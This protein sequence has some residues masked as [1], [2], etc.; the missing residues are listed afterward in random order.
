MLAAAAPRPHR[1]PL[2]RHQRPPRPPHSQPL[3][4]QPPRRPWR[5]RP[6]HRLRRPR[7]AA[8]ATPSS[9]QCTRPWQRLPPRPRQPWA[10]RSLAIA[11][12]RQERRGN[13]P[14]V[15]G[16]LRRSGQTRGRM[17]H[18]GGEAG[19]HAA[20]LRGAAERGKV[21]AGGLKPQPARERG[22]RAPEH[23]LCGHRTGPCRGSPGSSHRPA[24]PT[25]NKLLPH[26]LSR[27]AGCSSQPARTAAITSP[28]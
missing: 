5:R 9:N 23:R 2:H 25:G 28:A 16:R 3:P 8:P 21:R 14:A 1:R 6:A 12:P 11:E 7:P 10:S 13:R 22:R 24:L 18:L 15:D 17:G 4:R 26:A 19:Q 20:D 27:P